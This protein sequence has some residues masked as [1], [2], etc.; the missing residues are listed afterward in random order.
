MIR[1]DYKTSLIE[2]LCLL[3]HEMQSTE[4]MFLQ[5]KTTDSHILVLLLGGKKA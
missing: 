1:D 2:P 5:G 4:I 3:T